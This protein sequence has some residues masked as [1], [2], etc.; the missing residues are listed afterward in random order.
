MPI[1]DGLFSPQLNSMQTAM[2]LATKRQSLLTANLANVNVAGYKRKDISFE[3]ALQE[4]MGGPEAQLGAN[5]REMQD[6]ANQRAS[7]QTS[8]RVDGN[9]VDMEK[10]VMS[11]ADTQLRF[12]AL[13]TMTSD[14][15]NGLKAAIREG[16]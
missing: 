4:T 16:K 7:D 11:I 15:F 2:G 3:L 8:I 13:T 6:A 12:D 14:Y 10:E 1:L 9:N 5:F